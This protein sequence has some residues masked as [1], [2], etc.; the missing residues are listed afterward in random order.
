MFE[1]TGVPLGLA[2]PS[3]MTGVNSPLAGARVVASKVKEHRQ[4]RESRSQ[5]QSL[6]GE[7]SGI[8]LRRPSRR[9]SSAGNG[10]SPARQQLEDVDEDGVVVEKED[11]R[12][13]FRREMLQSAQLGNADSAIEE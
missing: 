12:A 4:R 11:P 7:E 5:S 6:G 9:R 3:F 8:R 13:A 1:S 10:V 2:L